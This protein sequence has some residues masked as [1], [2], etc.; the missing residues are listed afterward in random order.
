MLLHQLL[1][2]KE[3]LHNSL[4]LWKSFRTLI[5]EKPTTCRALQLQLQPGYL[6]AR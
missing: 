6:M 1:K 5:V 2:E 3:S 4:M